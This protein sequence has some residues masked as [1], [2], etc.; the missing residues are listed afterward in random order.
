MK[1]AILGCDGRDALDLMFEKMYPN[2]NNLNIITPSRCTRPE[3]NISDSVL[4]GI[5]QQKMETKAL[6]LAMRKRLLY[7]QAINS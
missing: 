3:T 5:I 6:P 4:N 7:E 1:N 2:S